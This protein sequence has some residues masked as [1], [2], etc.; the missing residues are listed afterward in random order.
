MPIDVQSKLLIVDDLPENLLA[1]EALIRSPDRVV[2]RAALGR[3]GALADA[4][5]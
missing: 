3:G 2:F 1:L 4:G 5:A